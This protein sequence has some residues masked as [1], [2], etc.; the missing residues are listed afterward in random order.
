MDVP[1]GIRRST[2]YLPEIESLRGIAI[3]LVFLFH[4]DVWSTF[5]F[6]S[7]TGS[8]P[9]PGLG[10]VWSGH[11]GVT[12]FFI[13]SGFLLSLP[14]LEEASG[15][16]RVSW[17]QFYVRRALRIL[18]LYYAAVVAGTVITARSLA[19]LRRGVPYVAFLESKPGL[20]TP[21][22]PFSGVWWSLA[23][24]VQFYALLPLVA[25]AFGRSR[26]TTLCLLAVYGAAVLAIS[27]RPVM[28][29]WVRARLEEAQHVRRRVHPDPV[30][31]VQ[32]REVVEREEAP[33]EAAVRR[34]VDG[35]QRARSQQQPR[36]VATRLH[37]ASQLTG[38][39]S[40][41]TV[42]RCAPPPRTTPC[43]G[44]TSP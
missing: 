21:M 19:D 26:R 12:L 2:T 42:M 41:A 4:A 13:L 29:P 32:P 8:W 14:F 40:T 18:P 43:N 44:L 34:H 9:S 20:T 23:T 1:A 27:L 17:R 31:H 24:E 7:R 6:R 25:L 22:P 30:S 36:P 16:R 15:G 33:D 10:Y 3:A 37:R 38:V 11:T 35:R 5:P 28:D 39:T